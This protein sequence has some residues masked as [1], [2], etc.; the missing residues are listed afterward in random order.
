MLDKFTFLEKKIKNIEKRVSKL[1]KE[2][3]EV[4]R[5]SKGMKLETISKNLA[6]NFDR[7]G[8]QHLVVIALK[9]KSKQTKK[10]LESLLLGWGAKQTI[11]GWFKDGNLSAYYLVAR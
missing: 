11:H 4:S 10:Q 3:T 8:P 1:E 7:L 2:R 6:D 9:L 5:S